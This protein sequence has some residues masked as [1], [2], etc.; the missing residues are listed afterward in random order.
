MEARRELVTRNL[1]ELMQAVGGGTKFAD[2]EVWLDSLIERTE[3]S[4]QPRA[5]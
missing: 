2:P 5:T 1:C 3:N 4:R